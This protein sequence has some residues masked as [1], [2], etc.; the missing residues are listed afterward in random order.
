MDRTPQLSH[1]DFTRHR[2]FWPLILLITLAF[3]VTLLMALSAAYR[4]TTAEAGGVGSCAPAFLGQYDPITDGSAAL[5]ILPT[6]VGVDALL[7]Q[8]GAEPPAQAGACS[9][10]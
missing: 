10:P 4:S 7:D 9:G 2:L 3:V 6:L 8:I 5:P 1:L